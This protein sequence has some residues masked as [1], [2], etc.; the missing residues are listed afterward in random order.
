MRE[1][2]RKIHAVHQGTEWPRGVGIEKVV[3]IAP[4]NGED[5]VVHLMTGK[6]TGDCPDHGI[7][8]HPASG[9]GR[10]FML[11]LYRFV[12]T[13]RISTSYPEREK[14][15]SMVSRWSLL[16]IQVNVF[17]SGIFFNCCLSRIIRDVQVR[18]I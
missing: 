3:I 18:P 16:T 2:T 15:I 8:A 14:G 13:F 17:P 12:S 10:F 9:P 5:A 6:R 4:F 11:T 1:L 7:I